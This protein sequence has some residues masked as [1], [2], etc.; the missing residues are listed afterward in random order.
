MIT[1]TDT[2]AEPYRVWQQH[3]SQ[4]P[5]ARYRPLQVYLAGSSAEGPRLRRWA[6]R[7]EQSCRVELTTRWFAGCESWAGKDA[8]IAREDQ[9]GIAS[10]HR[11]SLQRSDLLWL[12]FPARSSGSSLV[13]LG[14]ALG[15]T[16][17]VVSG[18]GYSANVMTSLADYLDPSDDLAFHYVMNAAGPAGEL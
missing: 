13:E 11:A 14:L 17:T 3:A 12:L 9:R 15:R 6:A 4:R 18:P 8:A 10:E 7:L 2:G 16:R 1:N 5:L